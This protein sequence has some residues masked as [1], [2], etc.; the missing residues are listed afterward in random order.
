MAI[1]LLSD[2]PA[3]LFTSVSLHTV[4]RPSVTVPVLSNTTYMAQR[5]AYFSLTLK[6]KSSNR[7]NF[8]R[9]FQWIA[10]FYENSIERANARAYHN[11]GRCG[12]T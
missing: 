9:H 3:G 12:Q 6:W 5:L 4:G 10:T 11:R 2:H 7:S 8:M 1:N